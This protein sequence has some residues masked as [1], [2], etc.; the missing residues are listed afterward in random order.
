[1]DYMNETQD[2]SIEEVFNEYM[3]EDTAKWLIEYEI[4][5]YWLERLP[6]L[7]WWVDFRYERYR[8]NA[9]WN[10]ENVEKADLEC[11]IDEV[12]SRLAD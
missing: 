7:T 4:K 2:W 9:Y 11:T 8:L 10:L 3:S 6:Y 12:I 5:N 1:M